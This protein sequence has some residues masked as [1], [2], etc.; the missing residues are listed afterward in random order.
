[1][2]LGAVPERYRGSCRAADTV[3]A[4]ARGTVGTAAPRMTK[5][6]DTNYH[7]LVPEVG[8]APVSAGERQALRASSEARAAGFARG[9]S[10]WGRSPSCG[11]RQVGPDAGGVQR[12]GRLE[13]CSAVYVEALRRLAA[14]APT[15]CSS[16]SPRSWR[17]ICRWRCRRRWCGPTRCCGRPAPRL[18]LM[19]ATYFGPPGGNLE[20]FLRLP[21]AGVHV[22]AVRGGGGIAGVAGGV[23]ARADAVA[24]GGGWPQRL[25]HGF[26]GRLGSARAGAGERG[27][28]PAHGGAVLLAAARAVES[29]AGDGVARGGAAAAGVLAE[30]KL[31]EVP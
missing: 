25:A 12:R 6:F 21:V 27:H 16:T 19:V 2:L 29:A 8:P 22:D 7:H 24:G 4:M 1:M 18:R 10:R 14:G 20:T 28:R 9:P 17:W 15:G 5:W 11:W 3:F 13:P 30:E 31:G 26:G 23:S